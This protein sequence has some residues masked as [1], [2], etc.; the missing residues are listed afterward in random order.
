MKKILIALT[1]LFLTSTMNAQDRPLPQAGP[2]P[3]VQIKTPQTFTLKN[4]LKVLVVEDNKL[5]RVSY[6][7]SIDVAPY[8]EG[9]VKGV[10]DILGSMIGKGTKTIS[11]DD[12]H[13][14]ID[15][16]GADIYFNGSGAFA[17]SLSKN[18]ARVLELLADAAI[19]PNF[20]QDE[21]QKEKDKLVEGLKSQEKSVQ[22]T[23]GRVVNVLAYGKK[24]PKGEYI[25]EETINNITLDALHANYNS[26]FV[27]GNAYLIVIGDVK[28]KD[29]QKQVKKLFNAWKP[30]I[31]PNVT[32]SDPKNVQYTQINFVD[33]PNAVQSDLTIVNTVNL[34]MNNPDYFP[35]L[36]ANSIFGGDFNSYLNMNLREKHGWTY[37]ARSSVGASR[38]VTTFRASTQI[39]NAVTDS[40]VVQSLLELKRIRTEAVNDTML[41]N[42]KAGFIGK[43]VMG[44]SSPQSIARFALNTQT[45]K[46]PADFYTNYIKK[47]EAVTAED[48]QR[49]VNKYFLLD[50]ARIVVV[51]KATEVVP[52]LEKLDIPIFY[53]DRFGEPTTKPELKRAAPADLTAAKVLSD[54][55]QAI[56]GEK[57]TKAVKTIAINSKAIFQGQAIDLVSKTAQGKSLSQMS[58]MGMVIMKSMVND[59]GAYA[60]Q[61]GNRQ[62]ITGDELKAA[63][64]KAF[65]FVELNQLKDTALTIDGI[66]PINGEDTYVIVNGET[67]T[68][69]SVK[70]GLKLNESVTIEV[71]GNQIT[72]E[73]SYADYRDV[74][75]VKI[76]FKTSI[77]MGPMTLDFEVQD[78]KI[79]EGVSDADFN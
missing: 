14:E 1:G 33:M 69:Y 36:I 68:Y 59:K 22:A 28:F 47:I 8:A 41:K 10:S 62:E 27:P 18:G 71:M 79:N 78:V 56:G 77:G 29:V 75:G 46:L 55:I 52:A 23:A 13:E 44:A 66:E 54:Y 49:V 63:R 5:P 31:A 43:F 74:K 7:L 12:F 25:S 50:N 34:Q 76:P 58:A 39:R 73:I 16:L 45:E 26:Y 21:L 17:S 35:V 53:F 51:G 2:A 11:K 3:I 24:H 57:N 67:K 15:F 37:G 70:T 61:Q 6:N 4:G 38:Y 64:E 30:A 72:Q 9:N 42:V 60:E 20:T 19:N 40:A 48:I 32:Y 65:P